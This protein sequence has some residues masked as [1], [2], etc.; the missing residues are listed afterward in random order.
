M[1]SYHLPIWILSHVFLLYD[2]YSSTS[3]KPFWYRSLLSL[4]RDI[5]QLEQGIYYFFQIFL[6]KFIFQPRYSFSSDILEKFMPYWR[7]S[8]FFQLSSIACLSQSC[9]MKL[10]S[11]PVLYNNSARTQSLHWQQE[12]HLPVA[13]FATNR[14]VCLLNLTISSPSTVKSGTSEM[15]PLVTLTLFWS[16]RGS[17]C[18]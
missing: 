18:P 9:M 1:L 14:F 16:Y 5:S 8:T 7:S 2:R 11:M 6:K 12:L 15:W 13:F 17:L 4:H 3:S 10:I